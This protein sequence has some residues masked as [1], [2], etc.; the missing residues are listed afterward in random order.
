MIEQSKQRPKLVII[1][2]DR[3]ILNFAKAC[4]CQT[5]TSKYFANLLSEGDEIIT[6]KSDIPL[7]SSQVDEWLKIF[8]EK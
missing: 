6:E 2:S 3:E 5:Y 1:S 8:G 4:S 7:S